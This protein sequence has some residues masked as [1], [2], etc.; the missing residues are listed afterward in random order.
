MQEVTRRL[1][2]R[3]GEFA[4]YALAGDEG[5]AGN[6]LGASVQ[7]ALAHYRSERGSGRPEWP[8]PGFLSDPGD[9]A[10]IE[11]EVELDEA[12]WLWLEREAGEQGVSLERLA[13]HAVLYFAA[14]LDAGRLAPQWLASPTGSVRE[15]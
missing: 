3:L 10:A 13:E 6:R 11:L 15:R 8:C 7:S 9:D 4:I 14:D 1:A 2:L 5:P 12:L